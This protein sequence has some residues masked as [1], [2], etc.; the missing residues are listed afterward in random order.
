MFFQNTTVDWIFALW[1]NP[2]FSFFRGFLEVWNN[3]IPC[4]FERRWNWISFL[5]VWWFCKGFCNAESKVYRG[6]IQKIRIRA[7]AR[8]Y[9]WNEPTRNWQFYLLNK[10]IQLIVSEKPSLNPRLVS[11]VTLCSRDNCNAG[12]QECSHFAVTSLRSL[13]CHQ[14]CSTKF[15]NLFSHI[16]YG[17]PCLNLDYRVCVLS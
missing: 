13:C 17:P 7:G 11:N 12:D 10:C 2:L 3:T 1:D 14:D 8:G 9:F 4:L 16:I 15:E 6:R 5:Q